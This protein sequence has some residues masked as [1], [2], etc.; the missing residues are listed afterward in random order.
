[1]KPVIAVENISKRFRINHA[2]EPYLSI[3]DS[4]KNIFKPTSREDFYALKDVSFSVNEGDSVGIVGRN[5]AGKSTLL[6][7]LSKITP[8]TSGSITYRGRIASLLEV[9]TGF[10]SELTGREN[11]FM[12][13]SIL[14][15]KR[16]EIRK[17]FDS[18]VEFAGV[19]K[20]IDTPLKH[21]S[22]GMQLRLAFSVAAF[23][24]NEI[25][26]IDEVLA[27]GDADFQKKCIGKMQDVASQGRTVLYVSHNMESV[28]ALCN[29]GIVLNS[30]QLKFSGPIDEVINVY[31]NHY[32][33][34]KITWPLENRPGDDVV[35][36][37]SVMV[38]NEGGECTSQVDISSGFGI[39]IQFEVLNDDEAP[40]PN[41]HFYTNMGNL[42]FVAIGK[43]ESL[44]KGTYESTL[45]VPSN[46]MNNQTYYIGVALTT[47]KTM[48]I[49][50]Y[51]KEI[52]S[53]DVIENKL[54]RENHFGG[55]IPGVV[56]PDLKISTNKLW[57]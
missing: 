31:T 19:E 48:Q 14:G 44:K 6:K 40:V 9:G 39:K 1:M 26:V 18:I 52:V 29:K 20:F 11:V 24:E 38:V 15:M 55:V 41:F 22:S 49:H 43:D 53:I 27:V 28:L 23:L 17:N 10:H 30:G 36:L 45:M 56:R 25:L 2:Q 54:K 47:L 35:K 5:G 12:N 16:S 8:P 33:E 3:R 4:F 42:C 32:H 50:L 13:G 46:L 21:Y 51:E 57:E 37:N 34:S 7:I